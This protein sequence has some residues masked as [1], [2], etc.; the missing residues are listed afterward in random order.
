MAL[1]D[2]ILKALNARA[3]TTQQ[4]DQLRKLVEKAE[5][6]YRRTESIVLFK[7]PRRRRTRVIL[8]PFPFTAQDFLTC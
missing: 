1:E 3:I 5:E 4:A 7:R 6:S 2:C 8:P